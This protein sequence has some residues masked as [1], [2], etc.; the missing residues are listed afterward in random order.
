M[1][2]VAEVP[3]GDRHLG[4]EAVCQAIEVTGVAIG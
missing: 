4:G 3:G 2:V 1:W